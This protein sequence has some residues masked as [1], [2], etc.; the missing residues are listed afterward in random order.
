ML[1]FEYGIITISSYSQLTFLII[2]QAKPYWITHAVVYTKQ[3]SLLLAYSVSKL[4]VYLKTDL[5]A[6]HNFIF[7]PLDRSTL[8]RATI[9]AHIVDHEFSF[10]KVH[11]KTP[12]PITVTHHARIGTISN[13]NFITAYQV[14]KDAI[15][16]AKPLESKLLEF[17]STKL[18]HPS[19]RYREHIKCQLKYTYQLT[20]KPKSPLTISPN[21][22]NQTVLPNS[23]TVYSKGS[24]TNQLT[25]V[26]ISFNV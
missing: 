15:P 12:T 10:I 23:I 4:A 14:S 26:L 24:K 16:L 18:S 3:R 2:A 6:N 1:N 21:H 5:L 20:A 25:K 22:N 11:N 19:S 8:N 9:Y 7:N 13:T 17:K